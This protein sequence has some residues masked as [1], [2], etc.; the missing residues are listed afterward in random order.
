MFLL[1][2]KIKLLLQV[3]KTLPWN[4]LKV[5]LMCVE[6]NKRKPSA[7]QRYLGSLGFLFIGRRGIDCWFGWPQLLYDS[8]FQSEGHVDTHIYK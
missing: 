4:E 7:L 2:E 8:V 1:H 5:R 3:L 6:C